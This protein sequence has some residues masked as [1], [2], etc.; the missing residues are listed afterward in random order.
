MWAV[1]WAS[2]CADL[3]V[4]AKGTMGQSA[5]SRH[6]KLAEEQTLAPGTSRAFDSIAS[7]WACLYFFFGLL[8]LKHNCLHLIFFLLLS[9]V[10]LVWFLV[11]HTHTHTHTHTHAHTLFSGFPAFLHLKQDCLYYCE[12]TCAMSGSTDRWQYSLLK[13]QLHLCIYF[14][15]PSLS[16][17][18]FSPSAL[19]LPL[20]VHI[21]S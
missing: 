13:G 16:P 11:S 2:L 18:F 10:P 20:L 15:L 19:S 1:I 7:L 3:N 17:F 12:R 21:E 14:S 9:S 8:R 6:R 5:H 4:R